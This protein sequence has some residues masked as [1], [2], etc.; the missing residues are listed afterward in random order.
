M[1][2]A[3][4]VTSCSETLEDIF[5]EAPDMKGNAIEFCTDVR[6]HRGATRAAFETENDMTTA[7]GMYSPINDAYDLTISMYKK[8]ETQALATSKY[9]RANDDPTDPTIAVQVGSTPMYWPD[10]V[11]QYGFKATCGTE[12]VEADQSSADLLFNQD[13][14]LGYSYSPSY[15]EGADDIDAINYHTNKQWYSAN[16]SRLGEGAT[17]EQARRVPLYLQ[18]QRSWLTVI[19]KAGNGVPREFLQE[20]NKNF[21]TPSLFSYGEPQVT[22]TKPLT[23][24]V[25]I[26][27]DEDTNGEEGDFQTTQYDAIV[28][29]YDFSSNLDKEIFKVAVN[30]MKFTYYAHNDSVYNV[31]HDAADMS[32]Y[33]LTAG[34]HLTI[35]A[36]LSTD[37]VVLISALLEDWDELTFNS[38]CDDYGQ[39][40]V[41]I[42]ITSR[43]ELSEFLKNPELNK[44]GNTAILSAASLDLRDSAWVASAFPPL[45]A[46]L[47]MAG[48][49]IYTDKQVFGDLDA[50]ATI[51]NG[52]ISVCASSA[53]PQPKVNAALCSNNKGI[54]QLVNVTTDGK[55]CAT[56]GA[57]CDVNYGTILKCKSDLKVQ[58][59][60]RYIGGIAAVS[61][62]DD[63]RVD[64]PMPIIDN[65]VVNG[66]VGADDITSSGVLGVGGI[67]GYAEGRLTNNNFNYGIT[68]T[69]QQNDKCKNIVA[70]T[71]TDEE[72]MLNSDNV[73]NNVWPTVATNEIAG[74]NA[75]S[76]KYMAV[77]DCQ[78]ELETLIKLGRN[79]SGRSYR[80]A[81]DFDID[82]SWAYGVTEENAGASGWDAEDDVYNHTF[83]LDG[84]GRTITTHGKMIFSHING[85]IK[86]LNIYCAESIAEEP[87]ANST[88]TISPLA[89]SVNGENAKLTNI[90]VH[91]ANGTY[92]QS[93]QPAGLV[94]WAFDGA[95]IEDCETEVALLSKMNSDIVLPGEEEKADESRR[96]MGGLVA[97]AA[98]ATFINCRVHSG[99]TM[100]EVVAEGQAKHTN[101]FRGGIVGGTTRKNQE[102]PSL[103]I[104]NCTSWFTDADITNFGAIIG[105][106]VYVKNNQPT[107]GIAEGCQGNWWSD[108]VNPSGNLGNNYEKILGKKN[109]VSPG[110]DSSDWWK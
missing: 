27:Y 75:S 107:N 11:N 48:A 66:R 67:V 62:H 10:N 38:I 103:L 39:N 53:N 49:V 94:C 47:N 17:A 24:F 20:D 22:V 69:Y 105:R 45:K 13:A 83:I 12:T 44:A 31:N 4:L 3:G 102:D 65:C 34:K 57:V 73:Y 28:E 80:I 90:K 25:N 2:T 72:K 99:T 16:K 98:K 77:L 108:G 71:S 96:Y 97:F 68:I 63:D 36:V 60:S 21:V 93:S 6:T 14:L 61:K 37:R 7:L 41:P 19:L 55:S 50:S 32:A 9:A 59:N 42:E 74:E 89:Y 82:S 52:V 1:L 81:A 8:G 78:E 56:K 101:L 5:G 46:T 23:S 87:N 70:A 26:H 15:G 100:S 51:V 92:I 95:T 109:S 18:H 30:D 91:M 43:Y 64:A 84:N 110:N 35:T 58:G 33:N 85:E 29:P 79:A 106:T 54:I 76:A 40:G 86:N 88:N 104:Q